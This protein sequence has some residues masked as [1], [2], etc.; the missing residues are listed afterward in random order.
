MTDSRVSILVVEDDSESLRE[1][2]TKLHPLRFRVATATFGP[3]ALEFIAE[4]APEFV[5]FDACALY[6]QG[7]ALAQ[8][9][10]DLSPRTRVL[11]LDSEETWSLFLEPLGS[12]GS[13]TRINPCMRKE[14]LQ[15]IVSIA[16]EEPVAAIAEGVS[17]SI[18]GVDLD[19]RSCTE[20]E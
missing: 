1:L 3:A 19:W 15:T 9:V 2:S 11:F 6:L 10:R 20:Q 12:D 16:E 7:V 17:P 5:V 4:N 18:G 14:M 8:K 13:E